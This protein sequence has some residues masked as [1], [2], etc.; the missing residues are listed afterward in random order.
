MQGL[1]DA[2][3]Y[4]PEAV[5]DGVTVG[6]NH[7]WSWT[8]AYAAIH[9]EAP[10]SNAIE[11]LDAGCGTGVTAQ[12]LSHLNPRAI[13]FD[14]LD[15]SSGALKVARERAERADLVGKPNNANFHHMSLYDVADLG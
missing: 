14:A 11:M 5:F 15:L 1:Y 10:K 7:R 6:Y 9:G 3:P 13:H 2:Y 8:H 4:P 12:Y